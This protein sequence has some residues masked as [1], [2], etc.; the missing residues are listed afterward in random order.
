ME[1]RECGILGALG[2][3]IRRAIALSPEYC[4]MEGA[5]VTRSC[6]CKIKMADVAR[7]SATPEM[8]FDIVVL[9][10]SNGEQVQLLD[11]DNSLLELLR[12]SVPEREIRR[13]EGN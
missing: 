5:I 6:R 8:V 12:T 11:S 1:N 3:L 13:T 9:T 2:K 7:W 10:L 4:V